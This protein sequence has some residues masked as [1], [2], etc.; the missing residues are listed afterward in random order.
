MNVAS[1][2]DS[3]AIDNELCAVF[4]YATALIF[5]RL[6]SPAVFLII[7]SL[8]GV[9]EEDLAAFDD[10]RRSYAGGIAEIAR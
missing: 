8:G 3:V 6:P 2:N 5:A 10:N 4:T 1:Q 9:V 7:R